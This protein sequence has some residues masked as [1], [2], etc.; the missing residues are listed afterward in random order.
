MSRKLKLYIAG[1]VA[2]S[3]VA[4]VA[5]TL[6]FPVQRACPSPWLRRLRAVCATG[7]TV[8]LDRGDSVGLGSAGPNAARSAVHRLTSTV[9]AAT[10]LGG[11]AAGAWV[12][13]LGTTEVRELRGRVPWYG[14]LANHAGIVIPAAAADS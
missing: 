7:G 1:V 4:L 11:P 3:V 14:T 5:T 13:L 8:L 2:M 10:I 12:G 9:M 6:L